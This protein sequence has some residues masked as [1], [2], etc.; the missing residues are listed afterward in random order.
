ME[1]IVISNIVGTSSH[2][3]RDKSVQMSV[4]IPCQLSFKQMPEIYCYKSV[5]ILCY[6]FNDRYTMHLSFVFPCI[7]TKRHKNVDKPIV[8]H[9]TNKFTFLS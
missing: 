7:G 9:K 1:N 4:N 2:I 8:L 6:G 5:V 3:I